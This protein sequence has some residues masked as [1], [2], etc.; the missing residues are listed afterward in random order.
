MKKIFL[1]RHAVTELNKQRR[2][3]GVS[4]VCLSPEGLKQ[5][6]RVAELLGQEEISSIY[7]SPLKRC[8]ETCNPIA[9][10]HDIGPVPLVGLGEIDFG[11]WEALTFDQIQAD[12]PDE[13]KVWFDKPDDFTFPQGES[14]SDFRDRV[15][16]STEEILKGQGNCVVVAHG[17]SLRVVLCHL[18]DWPMSCLHSFELSSASLTI[19]EHYEDSTVVRVL[20]DTCHL[21]DE[22]AN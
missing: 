11:L 9:K 18:C 3:C 16:N 17:G 19:L 2:Y 7:T 10:S 4:D 13:V 20:N 6:Q 15:I 1:V 12:H 14:V 22:G 8:L 21:K 5:A